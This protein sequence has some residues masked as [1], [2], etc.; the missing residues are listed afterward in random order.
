[1][2]ILTNINSERKSWTMPDWDRILDEAD[3]YLDTGT[4]GPHQEDDNV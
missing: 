3:Y 1:M 2:N 4:Y